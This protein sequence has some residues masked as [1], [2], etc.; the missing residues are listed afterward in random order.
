M[1]TPIPATSGRAAAQ[2]QLTGAC[3][4]G[5]VW[6]PM[7]VASPRVPALNGHTDTVPDVIGRL[8][9]PINLAIFTEGNHIISPP[10]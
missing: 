9:A 3:S 2:Y 8:G 1:G 7:V 4:T 5:V 10:C 6:R